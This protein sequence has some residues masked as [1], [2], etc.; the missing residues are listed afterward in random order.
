MRKEIRSFVQLC[1]F[2]VKFIHYFSDRTALLTDLLRKSQPHKVTLTPACLKAFETF[3]LRFIFGPYAILLEVSSDAM[4]TVA[5]YASTLGI[6]LFLLQDRGE[7]L[8]PV[9]YWA[10]KLNLAERGNTYSAYDLEALA[11]CVA[12]KHWRC[13]LEGLSNFL[14]VT[15]HDILGHLPGSRKASWTSGKLVTCGTCSRLWAR[16]HLCTAREPWTKPNVGDHTFL[17]PQFNSCGMTRF[18]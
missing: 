3:K 17:R 9:S 15:D 11:I 6:A 8:Q 4:C 18:R 5:A 13:Y 1:N 10:R 14:V 12:A 7:G 16:W 2:Y